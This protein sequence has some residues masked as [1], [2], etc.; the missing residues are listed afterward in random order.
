M[1]GTVAENRKLVGT[2]SNRS[3]VSGDMRTVFA[4]DGKSAYEIA[5]KNG[6]EG[7]EGE[8][9]NSLKGEKGDKGD[10]GEAGKDG[11]GI[12]VKASASECVSIGDAYIDSEGNIQI[13]TTLPDT[14]VNGGQIKGEKGDKGDKGEKGEKGEDGVSV[15]HYWV[16]TTLYV[17]SASGTSSADLK[18]SAGD[19]GGSGGTSFSPGNGITLQNGVLSVNTTNQITQGSTLP[20]TSG[21]VYAAI[22]NIESLLAA[23]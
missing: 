13:L 23:I 12:S 8:W 1:E 3:S 19:S 4:K 21:A 18:G 17:T 6:F 2:L 9:L 16:G 10:A 14:F 15:T 22:G 20:V 5:V 7:T 11:T